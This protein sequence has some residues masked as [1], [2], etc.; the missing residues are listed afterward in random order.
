M[1]AFIW[2]V[3]PWRQA[4]IEYCTSLLLEELHFCMCDFGEAQGYCII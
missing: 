3:T 2:S 1:E 4:Q